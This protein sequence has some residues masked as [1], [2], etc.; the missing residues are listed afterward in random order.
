M[1]TRITRLTT[2][3]ENFGPG[4]KLVQPD[5][6]HSI[7]IDLAGPDLG[8]ENGLVQKDQFSV[9]PAISEASC[10]YTTAIRVV[11]SLSSASFSAVASPGGA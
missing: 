1:A 9:H 10:N 8:S 11:M 7:K 5:H 3:N 2:C 6:F 4:Q